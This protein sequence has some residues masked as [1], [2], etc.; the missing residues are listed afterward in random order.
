[1]DNFSVSK[2]HVSIPHDIPVRIQKL[3]KV[4]PLAFSGKV[5][6]STPTQSENS[7]SIQ[8]SAMTKSN[9]TINMSAVLFLTHSLV[10]KHLIRTSLTKAY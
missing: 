9:I 4:F 1:M 3:N 7:L 5:S 8:H 10:N 6:L 2:S